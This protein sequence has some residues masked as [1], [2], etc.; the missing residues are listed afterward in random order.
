VINVLANN[1]EKAEWRMLERDETHRPA[2]PV[3]KYVSAV[4]ARRSG[5]VVWV[6]YSR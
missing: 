6:S 1:E 2:L 5:G 4:S 3:V